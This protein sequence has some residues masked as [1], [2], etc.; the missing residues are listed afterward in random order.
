[1]TCFPGSV[2]SARAQCGHG[3]AVG[4]V[5]RYFDGEGGEDGVEE[6]NI[7]AWVWMCAVEMRRAV[8]RSLC[9]GSD[10]K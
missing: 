1:M 5:C 4:P 6:V 8:S 2:G 10:G 7:E 9:G 3:Y